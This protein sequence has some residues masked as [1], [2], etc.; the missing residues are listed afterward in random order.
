MNEVAR[1]N[2]V[3]VRR[4]RPRGAAQF[5]LESDRFSQNSVFNLY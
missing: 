1:K 3:V 4:T 2:L 5:N